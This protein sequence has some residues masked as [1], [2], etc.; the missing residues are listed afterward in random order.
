M[1]I[2]KGTKQEYMEVIMI[3]SLSTAV[4]Q[5]VLGSIL[6]L[7]SVVLVAVILFQSAKDKRLSGTIAGGA[8]TFFGKSKGKSTDKILSK[9]TIAVSVLVVLITI[10]LV[11]IVN[12][13]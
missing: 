12:C 13:L 5:Y 7:L 2:L 10:A 3:V 6:I 8:E 1:P 4:L 9:I 11:V